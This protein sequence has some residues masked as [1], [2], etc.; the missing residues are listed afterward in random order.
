M[1][2]VKSNFPCLNGKITID[3]RYFFAY[4]FKN[5]SFELTMNYSCAKKVL[6]LCEP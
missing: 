4:H 1:Y 6:S 5:D 3:N 2:I